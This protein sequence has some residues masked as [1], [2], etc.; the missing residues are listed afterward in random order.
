M[1]TTCLKKEAR[2]VTAMARRLAATV[3]MEPALAEAAEKVRIGE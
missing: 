1:E 3:L 2:E